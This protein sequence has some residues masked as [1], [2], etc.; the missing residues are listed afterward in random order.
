MPQQDNVEGRGGGHR[1]S[2]PRWVLVSNGRD[3]RSPPVI[4]SA[5]CWEGA[6]PDQHCAGQRRGEGSRR[7]SGRG[8]A[9]GE[10]SHRAGRSELAA[11]R[12]GGLDLLHCGMKNGLIVSF[13][14]I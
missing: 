5:P 6:R 9:G 10:G 2:A 8:G 13:T 7:T 14:A 3:H 1:G 12:D 11:A 4:G